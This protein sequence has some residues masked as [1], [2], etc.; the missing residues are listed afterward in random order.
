MVVRAG[1]RFLIADRMG[2]AMNL[3]G[4]N[5]GDKYEWDTLGAADFRAMRAQGFTF[6]RLLIRWDAIEPARGTY[7]RAYLARISRVLDAAHQGGV[8]VML[9]MHQDIFGPYFNGHRGIPAWATRTDG[10]PYEPQPNWF[11]EYFQPGVMRAFE[12]LYTDPDLQEAQ[13]AAWLQV[14]R[15]VHGHPAVLGYD[16][17]NEPFGE[18]A[19][20][21]DLVTASARI[22]QTRLTPMYRRLTAAIRTVDRHNWV[23]VEPT[24]LVGLGVPT[25]LGAIGDTRV[26]Y[27]PHFYDTGM[28]DG[29]DYDPDG[30]FVPAYE[31]AITAYPLAN[32]MPLLVGEWG[33]PNPAL[34]N[35][36]R[37][38]EDATSAMSRFSGGWSMYY[39]CKGGGYCVRDGSGGLRPVISKI[40]QPY[41]QRIAGTPEQETFDYRSETYTLV[42]KARPGSH[43]PTELFVPRGWRVFHNGRPAGTMVWGS[44]TITVRRA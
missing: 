42:V 19:P 32:R 31:Q 33:M 12:H 41:A 21:E 22:E 11:D 30:G 16:L 2:R 44:G 35:A 15:R 38:V 10:L 17:L 6:A 40:R 37:F 8:L 24:V 7:D 29:R 25:R 43:G 5:V 18:I 34:P 28:E 36:G 27:A 23:F 26:G 13:V 4:F 9:D 39:W 20:G 14:V 3:R 1:D